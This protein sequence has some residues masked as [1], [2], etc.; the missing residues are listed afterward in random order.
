MCIVCLVSAKQMILMYCHSS[1][2]KKIFRITSATILNDIL[3]V[4]RV[5]MHVHIGKTLISF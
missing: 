2:L 1:F 4:N 3:T 5:I